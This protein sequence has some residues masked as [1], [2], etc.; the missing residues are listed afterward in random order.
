MK[1]VKLEYL[2]LSILICVFVLGTF[3]NTLVHAAKTTSGVERLPAGIDNYE[4]GKYDDAIF[5]LEMAVYQIL[6]EEV[7][8]LWDAHLYL[9]L[10]YLLIGNTDESKKEFIKASSIIKNRIPDSYIH[11]PKVV[12][13]FEESQLPKLGEVWH[14]PVTGIEFV[15][16]MGGCFDMGDN[17]G[18]EYANEKP[19]HEV[20]VDN[21]YIGKHEVTQE[22]WADVM[23]KNPSCYKSGNNYPVESVSWSDVQGFIN[24]LN[25]K[26][27]E[28][29]RLPTEAEWEYAAR[30][31]GK[32]EKFSGINEKSRLGSYAWYTKNSGNKT[33]PV[34]QKK[35]NGIGIYDMTG[36]VWEWCQDWYG[37]YYYRDSPK[38]NPKGPSSAPLLVIRGGSWSNGPMHLRAS[39]R[40]YSAPGHGHS[41]RGFRLARTP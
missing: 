11:S 26:T 32:R 17:F 16:V 3:T 20:C 31:G 30:S 38:D 21:F 34:G 40:D 10:S 25:Q 8:L 28:N 35:P 6:E 1:T 13:L 41:N 29:Y 36:N 4:N 27:G 19:V 5:N 9:G 24:K 22:Q 2:C 14:D 15:F 7:E 23:D 33:H 37:R 18:D 39:R 12:K